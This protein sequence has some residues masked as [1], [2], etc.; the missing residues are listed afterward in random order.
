MSDDRFDDVRRDATL[1]DIAELLRERYV[2]P[3]AVPG[4]VE[5]L[6]AGARARRYDVGEPALFAEIVGS[7]LR[8][9]SR[10][11]HL[12]VRFDPAANAALRAPGRRP[13]QLDEAALEAVRRI[14]YGL[15]EQRLLEGNVRYLRITD[16]DW[17]PGSTDVAY[18]SAVRFLRDAD[19]VVIDLRGNVGGEP[20]AVQYLVSHFLEPDVPV[21]TFVEAGSE[22]ED[23]SLT[24]LPAGRLVGMPLYVLIDG[25]TYSAGEAFAYHVREFG[26]GEV[27]GET[28]AGA[29]HVNERLP[30]GSEFVLS[31]SYGRPVHPVTGTSW[32]GTG[33]TP[34][35]EAPAG[36]A[37][38]VAHALALERLAAGAPSE[39]LRAEYLWARVAVEARRSPPAPPDEATL[40]SHAGFYGPAD[41][42][43]K[44]GRL[45]L[46]RPGRHDFCLDPLSDDGL[47]GARGNGRLRVRFEPG[48]MLLYPGPG[49]QPLEYRR[50]E[51]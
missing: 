33:V 25:H 9:T 38:D 15:V 27:V 39:E 49:A 26:L 1:R 3:G 36:E 12:G 29:A 41:V 10:D 11:K 24:S 8:E 2:M 50:T 37:L 30:V 44:D 48:R 13:G 23:R 21:M 42:V 43:L 45:W 34:T 31:V 47:Y 35:V 32:E 19:A 28:T 17:V 20:L 7:D 5:R 4:I 14:H 46:L 22:T 18:D 51:G 40:A 6:E 16:F